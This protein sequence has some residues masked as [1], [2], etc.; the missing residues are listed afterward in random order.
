MMSAPRHVVVFSAEYFARDAAALLCAEIERSVAERGVC[1][2]VLSGGKTPAAVYRVMAS[3]AEMP[4]SQIDWYFGDERCV[5][6]THA[7]SNYRMVMQNL[8]GPAHILNANIHRMR[9]ELGAAMAA[10]EYRAVLEPLTEPLFDLVLLGLGPDGHTASLFPGDDSAW[11]ARAWVTTATAP[12]AFAVAERVTLT[13]RALSSA[14]LVCTLC[15]GDEKAVIRRAILSESP[16]TLALPAARIFGQER[17]LWL[18]D[19]E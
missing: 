4:W 16:D 9:G 19:F 2:V 13:P 1:R 11:P 6:P 7:D 10:N 12:P 15:P 8:I 3:H 5:P 17:T 14:R 18:V